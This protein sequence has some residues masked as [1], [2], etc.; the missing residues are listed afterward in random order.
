MA[1]TLNKRVRRTSRRSGRRTSRRASHRL[2]RR[3]LMHRGGAIPGK[4]VRASCAVKGGKKTRKSTKKTRKSRKTSKKVRKSR[5]TTKKSRKS[6]KKHD[7]KKSVPVPYNGVCPAGFIVRDSYKTHRGTKVPARC[8]H[9]LTYLPMKREKWQSMKNREIN[10]KER[11]ANQL[12]KGPKKCPT[13][14]ILR[15]GSVRKAY[16]RSNGKR[17]GVSVMPSTCIKDLGAKGKNPGKIPRVTLSKGL[18]GRYGYADVDSLKTSQRHS[19]LKHAVEAYN[20]LTVMRRLK[21]I[22]TLNKR[23]NPKIS[24]IFQ[25]DADW[26]RSTY[27]M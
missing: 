5:K 25:K 18:L 20:P 7:F 14:M 19:A 17:V 2:S 11:L 27:D 10:A 3:R 26:I 23:T 24:R 12:S 6:T 13:G 8:I 22:A 15:K 9:K 4:S 1:L 21:Y 16:T